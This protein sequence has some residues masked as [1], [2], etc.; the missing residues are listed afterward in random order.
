MPLRH[1][2]GLTRLEAACARA[3]KH[4]AVGNKSVQAV[5]KNRPDQQASGVQRTRLAGT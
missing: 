3:L 1:Q 5:L 4:S 2:F